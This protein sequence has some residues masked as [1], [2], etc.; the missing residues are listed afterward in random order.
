MNPCER[1]DSAPDSKLG[2]ALRIA[3][4][5][6]LHHETSHAD[7]DAR[8]R[9]RRQSAWW[10]LYVLELHSSALM[11]APVA[12][13]ADDITVPLPPEDSSD[14]RAN[15]LC[16]HVKLS[17]VLSR[18]IKSKHEIGDPFQFPRGLH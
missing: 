7:F 1:A 17:R 14:L 18:I 10:T 4:S 12:V 9:A 11:G 5:I 8:E 2:I 16:I 15:A 6:G 3:L 13:Q